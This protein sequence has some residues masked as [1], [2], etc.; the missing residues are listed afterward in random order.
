MAWG[1][2]PYRQMPRWVRPFAGVSAAECRAGTPLLAPRSV[3][4]VRRMHGTRRAGEHWLHHDHGAQ[5]PL[6]SL[7]HR[8]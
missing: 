3:I 5:M 6:A 2:A 1:G 7:V 8:F 4:V